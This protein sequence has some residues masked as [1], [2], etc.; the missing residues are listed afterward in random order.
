MKTGFLGGEL[1]YRLLCFL[2]RRA[3]RGQHR[4]DR[5][6][7]RSKIEIRFGGDLWPEVTGRVVLDFGCGEGIE[8]IEIAR[9]G[10]RRVI[11]L[12]IR[13][14]VLQRAR[15]AAERAEVADRCTFVSQT[16]ERADVLLS[17]DGFEHYADPEEALR[18]MRGLV[19]PHGRVF[20]SFGP[21]WLHPMGGHIFSVIPWAHLIFTEK[22]LLRWRAHFK[23]DGAA[24]FC[25]VEGGLNQMTI[26][27]F[28][29]LLR[30]SDFELESFRAVPIKSV[31]WL[32]NPL[33]REYL[34]SVV[35]CTLLPRTNI[36]KAAA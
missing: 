9:R 32:S 27:R 18:V 13:E 33:T 3:A 19:E 2:G 36:K 6:G 8:A 21:P 10:A 26:R 30:A 12:D 7:D 5:H 4:L 14:K 24:R 28:R 29:E 1:G 15:V 23:S 25:E 34:T 22:V 17:L 35:R 20:I 16:T 31:R 11:G